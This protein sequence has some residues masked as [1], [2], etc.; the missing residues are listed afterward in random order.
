[1]VE[2]RD[3]FKMKMDLELYTR[4]TVRV[5]RIV[6]VKNTGFYNEPIEAHIAKYVQKRVVTRQ[7]ASWL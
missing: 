6:T 4:A 5:Y 1:M 3:Y 2:T 7:F